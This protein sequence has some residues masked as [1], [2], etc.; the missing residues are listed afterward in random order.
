MCD[1]LGN[2]EEARINICKDNDDCGLV[3]G[4]QMVKENIDAINTQDKAS[5]YVQKIVVYLLTFVTIIAVLYI[6]YA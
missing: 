5:E 2:C 4:T 3:K 6:I 1:I